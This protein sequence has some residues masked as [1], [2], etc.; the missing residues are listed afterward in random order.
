MKYLARNHDS[1]KGSWCAA[2]F[3][4]CFNWFH[5]FRWNGTIYISAPSLGSDSASHKCRAKERSAHPHECLSLAAP[6]RNGVWSD[7][8]GCPV[9]LRHIGYER[10]MMNHGQ[11]HVKNTKHKAWEWRPCFVVH[12]SFNIQKLINIVQQFSNFMLV[13]CAILHTPFLEHLWSAQLLSIYVF[14]IIRNP[15]PVLHA[16]TWLVPNIYSSLQL[17]QFTSSNWL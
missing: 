16:A 14:F 3:R 13:F 12:H 1:I 5:C 10:I 15:T 17:W 9:G 8:F 4:R 2:V 11:K 6:R 7:F